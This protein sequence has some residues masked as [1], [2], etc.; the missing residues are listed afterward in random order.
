M[1]TVKDSDR[2]LADYNYH[3]VG[4]LHSNKVVSASVE[5]RQYDTRDRLTQVTT[6]NVNNSITL[7]KIK[8]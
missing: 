8:A 5:S 1:D 3:G 2:I 7:W 4:N 6:K